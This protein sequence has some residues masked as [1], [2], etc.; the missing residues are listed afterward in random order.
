M[1]NALTAVKLTRQQIKVKA[2]IATIPFLTSEGKD[3]E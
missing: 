2:E 3:G 1:S